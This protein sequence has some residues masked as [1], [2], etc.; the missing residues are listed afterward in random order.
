MR[1][2][3]TG[4]CPTTTEV[5]SIDRRTVVAMCRS[6]SGEI[7]LVQAH[8]TVEDILRYKMELVC[9]FLSSKIQV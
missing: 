1:G 4:V 7:Q 3:D 9:P 5:E 8:C 6:G 2:I